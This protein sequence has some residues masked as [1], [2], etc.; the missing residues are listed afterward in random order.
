MLGRVLDSASTRNWLNRCLTKLREIPPLIC[1]TT[2]GWQPLLNRDHRTLYIERYGD[3]PSETGGL[4]GKAGCEY[5]G[6]I[7]L[8]MVER[9]WAWEKAIGVG[10]E[11]FFLRVRLNGIREKLKWLREGDRERC[12]G[13]VS[14]V[15]YEKV[16]WALA[17][18]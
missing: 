7:F 4:K 18:E 10:I 12:R 5:D 6:G 14:E 9:V 17:S 3:P 8:W 11:C 13:G 15:T 16:T 1:E 2:V